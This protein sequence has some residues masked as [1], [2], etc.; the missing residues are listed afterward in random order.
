VDAEKVKIAFLNIIIN[1]IE[2]MQHL[3]YGELILLTKGENS[4]CIIEISDNGVG[5]DDNALSRLFEPY[6]TTKHKGNGLGLANTHNIIL[7]HRGSIDVSSRYEHGTKFIIALN[8][9]DQPYE[10]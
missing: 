3:D 1:A 6:Y 10:D 5:M 2:A 7:N 4:K 8:F 9:T